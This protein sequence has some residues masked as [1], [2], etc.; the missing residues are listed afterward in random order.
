[1]PAALLRLVFAALVLLGSLV[2]ARAQEFVTDQTFRIR[3]GQTFSEPGVRR[4]D[5][6][7][8]TVY[9]MEQVGNDIYIGG[10]FDSVANIAAA[11]IARYD[12]ATRTWH[13][14]GQGVLGTVFALEYVYWTAPYTETPGGYLYVGGGFQRPGSLHRN[15]AYWRPAFH[16]WG[17]LGG[18]TATSYF[19]GGNDPDRKPGVYAIQK[20]EIGNHVYVGGT[21]DLVEYWNGPESRSQEFTN[22]LAVFQGPSG[23]LA[24]ASF[25]V[26]GSIRALESG[27]AEDVGGTFRTTLTVGGLF[28]EVYGTGSDAAQY[29]NIARYDFLGSRWYPMGPAEFV[30]P[31]DP[32]IHGLDGT[33]LA[34][35]TSP[36]TGRLIV[37]GRFANAHGDNTVFHGLVVYDRSTEA[38]TTLGS[39]GAAGRVVQAVASNGTTI[40]VAGAL[41]R[42]SPDDPGDVACLD[43]SGTLPRTWETV[44]DAPAGTATGLVYAMAFQD[45]DV[46]VGGLFDDVQHRTLALRQPV[47]SLA[48]WGFDTEQYAPF[49][50]VTGLA[51]YPT[52]YAA[53][54]TKIYIAGIT[55]VGDEATNGLV[56][57]D[58]ASRTF[59]PMD[60]GVRGASSFANVNTMLVNGDTLFLGGYFQETYD[61]ANGWLPR[62]LFAALHLP[63]NTWIP[64]PSLQEDRPSIGVT[65][66]QKAEDGRIYVGGAVD[67]WEGGLLKDGGL[68]RWRGPTFPFLRLG[69]GLER[70]GSQ[71]P[72]V[73]AVSAFPDGTLAVAGAFDKLP[74]PS[75]QLLY[76]SNIA[77]LYPSAEAWTPRQG[78]TTAQTNTRYGPIFEVYA[79]TPMGGTG[80]HVL[81]NGTFH[82]PF[83]S[84]QP[85]ETW[86]F[87]LLRSQLTGSQGT[88]FRWTWPGPGVGGAIY[89]AARRGQEWLV[90][91]EFHEVFQSD[92]TALPVSCMAKLDLLTMRWSAPA[93][94]PGCPEETSRAARLPQ[95][96]AYAQST[97]GVQAFSP[98]DFL[99]LDV[100]GMSVNVLPVE[101]AAFEALADGNNVRLVW[102]TASE[103]NNLGFDVQH[104]QTDGA[105][106]SLAFVPGHGTTTEAHAYD[107]QV[108]GLE[109][110]T[111]AFRLRQT[112]TDGTVHT[113]AVV[114]VEVGGDGR[115]TLVHAGP[116]PTAGPVRVAFTV[117]DDRPVRLVLYDM[118]GRQVQVVADGAFAPGR[119]RVDVLSD[120]LAAGMYLLRLDHP[121]GQRILSVVKR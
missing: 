79:M 99:F 78:G 76:T 59:S 63:T 64:T 21:F 89:H 52:A 51:G 8:G 23:L 16:A 85:P 101:L 107:Y 65:L 35:G 84:A 82:Y 14:L 17:D 110:G 111:H 90:A 42:A 10:R 121:A 60:V 13:P 56:A 50:R 116:H 88:I 68:L 69:L 57:Y 67:V 11:N 46:L 4:L 100:A 61:E 113:S 1:M 37:G 54:D 103:T 97:A 26:N 80:E 104:G 47:N 94:S 2:P 96:D 43:E 109:A 71:G 119:H 74:Q 95:G 83:S 105:W 5:G 12:G 7:P 112:D 40:C 31:S 49:H 33:V 41:P 29:R 92:G 73:R 93:Y 62:R 48:R 102:Q 53:S 106:R 34:F 66:I 120:G 36:F 91:G 55:A 24:P 22:N 86:M 38:W 98:A 87:G 25:G 81:V 114:A 58:P 44:W 6:T 45:G 18:G 39:P 70:T 77:W 9:A 108:I 30:S 15:L 19:Y 32:S 3:T 75:S 72:V 117:P 115:L 20:T 118:L 28:G 27:T